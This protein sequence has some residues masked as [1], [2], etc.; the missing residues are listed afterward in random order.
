ML[1]STPPSQEKGAAIDAPPV[2]QDTWS[3]AA[4]S[5]GPLTLVNGVVLFAG[6]IMGALGSV[7]A[8]LFPRSSVGQWRSVM[9]AGWLL[10]TLFVLWV[11]GH[12][13]GNKTRLDFKGRIVYGARLTLRN[14]PLALLILFMLLASV[15]CFYSRFGSANSGGN[16]QSLAA[17]ATRTEQ[18]AL[19]AQQAAERT[20]TVVGR[21]DQK[22]DVLLDKTTR[23]EREVTR[24]LTPREQLARRGIAWDARS[25]HQALV[26][27]DTVLL[28]ELLEAGWSPVSQAPAGDSGN[29]LGH[30]LGRTDVND[31]TVPTLQ[32]LRRHVDLT[33]PVVRLGAWPAMRAATIAAEQCN[34]PLIE[35]LAS[36][37]VDVRVLDAPR[38]RASGYVFDPVEQLTNWRPNSLDRFPCPKQDR[39]AILALITPPIYR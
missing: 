11:L 33:K 3:T 36:V 35:A 30:L 2:I 32:V 37:G 25:Y 7:Y 9:G 39:A 28:A 10:S 19:A 21:V 29:S 8:D 20:E 1:A 16:L 4:T 18:A 6:T 17:M 31:K 23:I 22:T 34:R 15:W 12:N 27:G 13:D 24:P 5:S 38:T 26:D 14:A